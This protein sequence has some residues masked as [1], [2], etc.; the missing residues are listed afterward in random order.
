MQ[1]AAAPKP[2]LPPQALPAA[3]SRA[4]LARPHP[5]RPILP[6]ACVSCGVDAHLCEVAYRVV[7][8]PWACLTLCRTCQAQR[9]RRTGMECPK[10]R[11]GL[12]ALGPASSYPPPIKI[13]CQP[14]MGGSGC[15]ALACEA[16]DHQ[17]LYSPA[18]GPFGFTCGAGRVSNKA[19]TY[20][21][22]CPRALTWIVRQGMWAPK[23]QA[24]PQGA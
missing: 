1:A 3:L 22:S 17:G 4:A 12:P 15:H 18:K 16:C 11:Q 6:P 20:Q 13:S 19:P 5:S 7:A 8:G 10:Q 14:R 24:S 21:P 9:L 2:G 23:P